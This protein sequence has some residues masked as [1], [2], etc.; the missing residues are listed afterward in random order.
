LYLSNS[1]LN[2]FSLINI[3]K[4]CWNLESK[5]VKY[6]ILIIGKQIL[7]NSKQLL[8]YYIAGGGS[9][10]NKMILH[11]CQSLVLHSLF[12]SIPTQTFINCNYFFL[13]FYAFM[14]KFLMI[15]T[16][17]QYFETVFKYFSQTILSTSI[18]YIL[19]HFHLCVIYNERK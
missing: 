19:N 7:I 11:Q 14:S 9:F 8:P 17:A 2:E 1:F 13:C 10:G 15:V 16:P 4:L 18:S 6:M 3:L 12:F 5:N